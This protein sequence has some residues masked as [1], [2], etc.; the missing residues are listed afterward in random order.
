MFRNF[1][2]VLLI[3]FIA[4]FFYLETEFQ[5]MPR[6]S[7]ADA[8]LPDGSRYY[9][10]LKDGVLH[11]KG[12]LHW[13]N[14][15]RL[16]GNF[17]DGLIEGDGELALADGGHYTGGFVQG[18]FQGHGRLEYANGDWYEGEFEK[19]LFQGVGTLESHALGRYD[20]EFKRNYFD[21]EG[22][23]T[24]N[25]VSYSGHFENNDFVNG[26]ML[27]QSGN[28]FEGQFKNWILNGSGSFRNPSGD[29]YTGNFVDGVLQGEGEH[30]AVTGEYYKGE[31]QDFYYSGMGKLE[32][33]NG[34]YY[35]GEFNF[36]EFDGKGS[37]YTKTDNDEPKVLSGTWRFGEIQQGSR[38]KKESG[39]YL[40][41]FEKA[42][43]Q[44]PELLEQQAQSVQEGQAGKAEL[45]F[46]SVAGYG[47]QKVFLEETTRIAELM[48]EHQFSTNRNFQLVNHYRAIDQFP[49][50]TQTSLNIA[51]E[52][53]AGKMN[54]DED[55][56]FLYLTS[57]GSE[58]H[59]FSIEL[60]GVK[61]RDISAKDLAASLEQS[62]IKWKVIMISACY[63]GGF[64]PELE[65][66]HHLVMTAARKDRKSFGCSD[67]STMTYFARAYFEEALDKSGDF[68]A[69]FHRAE[70]LV[71]EWEA[72]DFPDSDAS[73]PQIS[74]GA[75]I[76]VKLHEWQQGL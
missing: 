32:L 66:E 54:L 51:L 43:Y 59:E 65:N 76:E 49:L 38:N 39:E 61:L 8:L 57:H 71:A 42:L 30:R 26:T 33:A 46:L 44:Q 17:V 19:G 29:E 27:D 75:A 4:Y 2:I 25:G 16:S 6:L 60:Q 40:S 22:V 45:F 3:G 13:T 15:A 37:Y 28:E 10:E 41:K 63:S 55:I 53:I 9:G 68:I 11:G 7:S 72:R 23:F 31:F 70:K 34:D 67:D 18:M 47:R 64:I 50:A 35:E 5:R 21:G 69:A 48:N 58:N 24:V 12:E 20:G 74:V 52:N 73:L 1:V 14:G 62:P 36:G 56:L